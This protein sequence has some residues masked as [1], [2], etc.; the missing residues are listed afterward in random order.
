MFGIPVRLFAGAGGYYSVDYQGQVCMRDKT[1]KLGLIPGAW[2]SAYAGA[3]LSLLVVEA[4]NT[5]EARLL[6]TYFVPEL[7]I[8][9]NKWPL[10]ACIELKLRMTPLR[11][12][13]W[14]LYRFRLCIQIS[15]KRFGCSIEIRWCSKKTLAEWWWTAKTIDRTMFNNCKQDVDRTPPI[16]GKC[17]ARQA[18]DK[19]YFVQWHAQHENVYLRQIKVA[20][21]CVKGV[22]KLYTNFT[23]VVKVCKG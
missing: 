6:E 23:L 10:K 15:C 11:I 14:L 21:S 7:R 17:T 18:A 8:K 5:I 9:I 3:S 16:A 1:F 22:N 12:R 13:V 2:V 19:T 20:L 4:G